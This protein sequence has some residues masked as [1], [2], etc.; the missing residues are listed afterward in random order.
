MENKKDSQE[1]I[2]RQKL[3]FGQRAADKITAF[4]GSWTFIIILILYIVV[5]ISLNIIAFVR[6]WDPWPF[7]ILNLTLSCL[8]TL[9]APLIL[10]S[11]N[12]TKERDRVE[13]ERDFAVNR[14]AERE[15]EDMQGDLEEIKTL[16]KKSLKSK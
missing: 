6:H 1:H 13:T 2:P 16:V 5:W 8:A 7:I 11:Q 12:R 3:T 15:I 10:M 4:A 9:Q 14:K